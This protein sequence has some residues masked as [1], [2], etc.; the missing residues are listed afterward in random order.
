MQETINIRILGQEYKV[1][2]GGDENRIQSLSRYINEK[3][4]DVQ[5]SGNAISTME[6][7]AIVMLSMADD[8]MNAKTELLTYKETIA[9]RIDQLIKNIESGTK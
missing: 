5:H 4:L 1:K 2:T 6:L 8:V 3:V 7:V 9:E